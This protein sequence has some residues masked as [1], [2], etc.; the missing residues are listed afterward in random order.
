MEEFS[1]RQLLLIR[2]QVLEYQAMESS[3]DNL[4]ALTK[5]VEEILNSLKHIDSKLKQALTTEW[6]E[7]ELLSAVMIDTE[8][9]TMDEE[10]QS[11]IS[12]AIENMV[13]MIDEAIK[14]SPP[15]A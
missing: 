14:K 10:S 2:K 6:W 12:K 8:S 13:Q 11:N 3:L 9:D 15:V 4:L 5:S 1:K 7:F